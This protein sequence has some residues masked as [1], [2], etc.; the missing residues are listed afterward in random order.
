MQHRISDRKKG[1]IRRVVEVA[2]VI[3]SDGGKPSLNTIFQ[4]DAVKD[5]LNPTGDASYYLQVIRSLTGRSK[6][7]LEEEIKKREEILLEMQ[8]QGMRDTDS[9]CAITQNYLLKQRGKL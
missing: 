8:N 3:P 6:A 2:E 1:I 5:A 7:E 9:V 4:W